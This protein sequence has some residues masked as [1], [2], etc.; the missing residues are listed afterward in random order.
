MKVIGI[1]GKIGSGKDTL[2]QMLIDINGNLERRAFADN[3]KVIVA[4]L[5]GVDVKLLHDQNFKNT[6]CDLFN[7]TYG[8]MLQKIG[9]NYLRS[10]DDKVWI[11]STFAS[12]LEENNYV[13]TDVRFKNEAQYIKD[14][15]GILIK[16]V[17]DPAKIRAN[18]NRD[19]NHPSEIDL[20]NW[21]NWDEIIENDS[22]IENLKIKAI[23]LSVKYLN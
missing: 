16:I 1:H 12:M 14:N 3:L 4:I 6:Y 2:A 19:P 11:K 23:S 17:G 9:T 8:E 7:M 15:G 18:S 21:T 22:T 13:I 10:F 20:D 5:T